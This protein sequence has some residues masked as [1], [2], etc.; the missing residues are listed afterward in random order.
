M[1]QLKK[2]ITIVLVLTLTSFIIKPNWPEEPGNVGNPPPQFSPQITEYIKM[3]IPSEKTKEAT[4]P[5]KEPK[6]SYAYLYNK[7]RQYVE[8]AS[9][10]KFDLNG[11]MSGITHS[12]GSS[13]IIFENDGIY[14]IDLYIKAIK[15]PYRNIELFTFL[16]NNNPIKDATYGS[17]AQ[18][19]PITPTYINQFAQIIIEAKSG[20]KLPLLALM[21]IG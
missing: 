2:A 6:R 17:L 12:P 7:K 1:N 5:R 10:I 4:A 15:D 8:G 19:G 20:D 16:L 9:T 3:E 21:K 11:P 13:E 18:E 14:S